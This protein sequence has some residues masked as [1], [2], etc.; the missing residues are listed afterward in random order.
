MPNFLKK[1]ISGV[2]RV[3]LKDKM[4]FF[5]HLGLMLKAGLPLREGVA[6]IKDQLKDN[7]F[8]K[9]LK[10]I[11][12]SIE[13]GESLSNSLAKHP[14]VFDKLTINVIKIGEES[15]TLRENLFYLADQFE[16]KYKLK[17]KIRAV[18]IYPALVL[19]ATIG[20]AVGLT[21]FVL[22][23][24]TSL[25]KSLDFALPWPTK[26]LLRLS[27]MLQ[28]HGIWILIA[29]VAL[30]IL[31]ITLSRLKPVRKFKH[32]LYTFLPII[33]PISKDKNLAEFSRNMG[34]LLQSGVPILRSLQITAD[35]LDNSV[36]R[37]KLKKVSENVK[38]GESISSNLEEFSYYFPEL[39]TRMISAGEKSGSLTKNFFYLGN[40]YHEK[41]NSTI[42]NL[43]SILEPVLLVVI[44]VLVG[45][46]AVS[47]LL[48]IYEL[49]GNLTL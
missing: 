32:R 36:Y 30:V 2:K 15:G 23:R 33:A 29:I 43:P 28:N 44:A 10:N 24:L 31:I 13:A 22:P 26:A 7:Y 3:S 41:V 46:V 48:P 20:L 38:A 17:R 21:V 4:I 47:I 39:A 27:E 6:T 8:K 5:K 12:T 16:E 14:G 34:L 37:E 45:F 42:E 9:V 35:S 19:I 18:M 40:F 49:T 1:I 25:F 11:L